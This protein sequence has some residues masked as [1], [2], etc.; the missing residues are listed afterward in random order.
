MIVPLYHLQ[1]QRWP[2]LTR[3]GEDLQQITVLVVVDENF[4]LLQLHKRI[5][6]I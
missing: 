5:F 6:S 4:Q 2:I 1:E 3:L